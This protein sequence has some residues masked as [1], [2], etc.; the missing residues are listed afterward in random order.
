MC[1]RSGRR[2]RS[3]GIGY[4]VRPTRVPI[5]RVGHPRG[6]VRPDA[7]RRVH[8]GHRCRHGVSPVAAL[9]RQLRP[10]PP[11]GR[12][13]ER[14]VFRTPGLRRVVPPPARPGRRAARRRDRRGRLAVPRTPGVPVGRR[15]RAGAHARAGRP[16]G[17]DRPLGE[18]AARGRGPPRGGPAH[19]RGAHGRHD[20]G[21][22]TLAR[23]PARP[24]GRAVRVRRDGREGPAGGEARNRP[25]GGLA[26]AKPRCGSANADSHGTASERARSAYSRPNV[27][28]I[29]RPRGEHPAI[30]SRG[31]G[32]GGR[33]RIEAAS[34][35]SRPR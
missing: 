15:R 13:L 27:R 2:R 25:P 12:P 4:L 34:T 6:H 7:R 23:R 8:D 24:A 18:L 3:H 1:E 31:C 30:R 20:R 5:S 33:S 17:V 26:T 28:S 21:V 14:A 35:A 16:R 11:P 29:P 32:C 9:L 10:L 22:G 19:L